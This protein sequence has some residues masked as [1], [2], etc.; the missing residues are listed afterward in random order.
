MTISEEPRDIRVPDI[1]TS[2]PFGDRVSLP[3]EN[4]VGFTVKAIPATVRTGNEER[5][6]KTPSVR[7]SRSYR[8]FRY[9]HGRAV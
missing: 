6:R 2:L 9:D 5:D 7:G 1:V 4:P 8:C 3:M